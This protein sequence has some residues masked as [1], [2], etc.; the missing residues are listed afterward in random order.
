MPNTFHPIL[1]ERGWAISVTL[2]VAFKVFCFREKSTHLP[3]IL[4][5]AK[6]GVTDKVLGLDAGADDYIPNRSLLM[7]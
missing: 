1:L 5:T 3:I 6:D 2:L 7:N 4:L